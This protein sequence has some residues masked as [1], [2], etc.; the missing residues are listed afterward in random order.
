MELRSTFAN[1]KIKGTP[2]GGSGNCKKYENRNMCET[3]ET[4]H[5]IERWVRDKTMF[6]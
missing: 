5:R 2:N 6:Q 1:I 3:R 4:G